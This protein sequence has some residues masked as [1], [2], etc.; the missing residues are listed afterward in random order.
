MILYLARSVFELRHFLLM[1]RFELKVF[2]SVSV[3]K[4]L[5]LPNMYTKETDWSTYFVGTVVSLIQKL[6]Y[7][8]FLPTSEI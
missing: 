5:N 3:K 7:A 1:I 4:Q 2:Y 8:V 6:I